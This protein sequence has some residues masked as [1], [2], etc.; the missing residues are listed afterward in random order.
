MSYG[1]DRS[2]HSQ[3]GMMHEVDR[4]AFNGGRSFRV[5][6]RFLL[7]DGTL[8]VEG[9]QGREV[10]GILRAVAMKALPCWVS[11]LRLDAGTGFEP[12]TFRL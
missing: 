5:A 7:P 3:L 11:A 2:V 12:V 9:E 6:H 8:A 1:L 10:N 4:P